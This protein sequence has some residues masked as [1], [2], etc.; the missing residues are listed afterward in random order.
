ME[1]DL[2]QPDAFFNDYERFLR[3]D[4]ERPLWDTI[5]LEGESST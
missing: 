5:K 2:E 4:D 3:I 1:M